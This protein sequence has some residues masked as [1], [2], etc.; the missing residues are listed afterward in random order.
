VNAASGPHLRAIVAE[1]S[2]STNSN[3]ER[4]NGNVDT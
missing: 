3:Q 1:G 4:R 2:S